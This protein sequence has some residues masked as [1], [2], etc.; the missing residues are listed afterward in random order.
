[1]GGVGAGT[2]GLGEPEVVVRGDVE[3]L[4]G[5]AGKEEVGVGEGG[6]AGEEGGG[7]GG[8]RGDGAG[9]ALRARQPGVSSCRA[10]EREE[11][12]SSKRT[13]ILRVKNESKSAVRGA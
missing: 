11:R 6:G 1:M 3:S 7:A 9:E 4:G 10:G 5:G 2:E 12:T 8:D 13:L